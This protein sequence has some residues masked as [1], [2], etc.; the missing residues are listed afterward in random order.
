MPGLKQKIEDT[1]EVFEGYL[2]D[3]DILAACR[4]K[5]LYDRLLKI[6]RDPVPDHPNRIEPRAVK[7]RPKEYDLLNKPR[8]VMRRELMK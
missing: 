7:R 5:F 2:T 8:A 6:A 4:A 1:R 3:P